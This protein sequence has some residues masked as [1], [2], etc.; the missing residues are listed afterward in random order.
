MNLG[1][2][3]SD[4]R[5]ARLA[6]FPKNIVYYNKRYYW[7][8]LPFEALHEHTHALRSDIENV[9]WQKLMRMQ[10]LLHRQ[11]RQETASSLSIF[12][13]LCLQLPLFYS[14]CEYGK[15]QLDIR[16]AR[17][18]ISLC[19]FLYIR[20]QGNDSE[21]YRESDL[22][23]SK[24][25][26]GNK[27]SCDRN[28]RIRD[29]E[30]LKLERGLKRKDSTELHRSTNSGEAC[31]HLK[32]KGKEGKLHVALEPV[33]A[34]RY[35]NMRGGCKQWDWKQC[36]VCPL[37]R[38]AFRKEG[39]KF[40]PLSLLAFPAFVFSLFK[41]WPESFYCKLFPSWEVLSLC[42]HRRKKI[43]LYIVF[44]TSC[45]FI[46]PPRKQDISNIGPLHEVTLNH[47]TARLSGIDHAGPGTSEL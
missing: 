28:C 12:P 1:V 6:L 45:S 38:E 26:K 30:I 23:K 24:Y 14:S 7:W 31:V 27:V 16:R 41:S 3:T 47:T 13:I 44:R 33:S 22:S 17:I 19:E 9:A 37:K 15:W 36:P 40:W 10:Q 32:S 43:K 25:S 39:P 18:A 34:W 5:I 29:F 2:R 42:Q 11:N 21:Q 46:F 4:G 35:I 20:S 8:M